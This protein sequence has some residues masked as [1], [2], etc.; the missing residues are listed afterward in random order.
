MKISE[1][2]KENWLKWIRTLSN[3]AFMAIHIKQAWCRLRADMIS[4]RQPQPLTE[5]SRSPSECLHMPIPIYIRLGRLRIPPTMPALQPL[6][7][8]STMAP[9]IKI[10][11]R[12]F[13]G[14]PLMEQ[15]LTVALPVVATRHPTRMATKTF[16]TLLAATAHLTRHLFVHPLAHQILV[17]AVTLMHRAAAPWVAPARQPP[18]ALG[19][20]S[21]RL[22][23]QPHNQPHQQVYIR[24][25]RSI[26]GWLLQVSDFPLL[27]SSHRSIVCPQKN[28]GWCC[29]LLLCIRVNKKNQHNKKIWTF[30]KALAGQQKKYRVDVRIWRQKGTQQ[31]HQHSSHNA[32]FESQNKPFQFSERGVLT[33][34]FLIIIIHG[35]NFAK[36]IFQRLFFICKGFSLSLHHVE[37]WLDA[38]AGNFM[39]II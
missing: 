34:S 38:S 3:R 27:V 13:Q 32:R 29:L 4:H 11:Q 31:K 8:R 2:I 35:N 25:T 6:V 36:K 37:V 5:V 12:Q 17:L 9:T 30:H 18:V 21:V 24:T 22:V 7:N 28:A 15:Q 20:L 19:T 1:S 39:E 23:H 10:V 26:H 33:I 16:G 14:Q